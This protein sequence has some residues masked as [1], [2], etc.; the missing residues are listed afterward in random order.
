MGWKTSLKIQAYEISR[1]GEEA[2]RREEKKKKRRTAPHPLSVGLILDGACFASDRTSELGGSRARV[3]LS[4]RKIREAASSW[5]PVNWEFFKTFFIATRLTIII[6][7]SGFGRC[8]T[9]KSFHG[10]LWWEFYA[11]EWVR[12]V[13]K[14]VAFVKLVLQIVDDA[15][16]WRRNV[17]RWIYRA[18]V[19]Q[20]FYKSEI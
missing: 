8:T 1:C 13:W 11:R 3:A 7:F 12:L 6:F 14:G 4:Y 9:W 5:K 10:W 2:R 19:F 16:D 15:I 18:P 17:I 20:S